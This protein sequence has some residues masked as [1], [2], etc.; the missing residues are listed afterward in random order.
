MALLFQAVDACSHGALVEESGQ[1]VCTL[2]GLV[3]ETHLLVDDEWREGIVPAHKTS[4]YAW[5]RAVLETLRRLGIS[6]DVADSFPRPFDDAATDA[7]RRA[8]A[9]GLRLEVL[10]AYAVLLRFGNCI[11]SE[12]ARLAGKATHK[13]W[14]SAA[15]VFEAAATGSP[16]HSCLE[17]YR[18]ARRAG[19]PDA[20]AQ[21]ALRAIDADPRLECCDPKKVLVASTAESLG[22]EIAAS[23]FGTTQDVP[24]LYRTKYR[25]QSYAADLTAP[26]LA[27]QLCVERCRRP[28]EMRGPSF[29][30]RTQAPWEGGAASFQAVQQTGYT[31]VEE[32][33]REHIRRC[34]G[35]TRRA[36]ELGLSFLAK[37]Q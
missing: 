3:L 7:S 16:E 6:L 25:I 26:G 15:C 30:G 24:K 37:I 4:F 19:L 10:A 33:L 14:R 13:E 11:P 5:R 34:A 17:L 27:L 29:S 28:P 2:C 18:E 21:A 31:E 22:D 35:C 1:R 23:I 12:E 32:P 8:K 9:G 36:E 20:V